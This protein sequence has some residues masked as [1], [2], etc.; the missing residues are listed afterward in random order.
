[1]TLIIEDSL[2]IIADEFAVWLQDSGAPAFH[3]E[4]QFSSCI[5]KLSFFRKTRFSRIILIAQIVNE[6]PYV[7]RQSQ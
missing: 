5:W 4:M 6:E 1:M 7:L 3:L 2:L